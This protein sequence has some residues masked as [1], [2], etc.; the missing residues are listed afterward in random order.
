MIKTL[1]NNE[2]ITLK[3]PVP[4]SKKQRIMKK[5]YKSGILSFSCWVKH[6]DSNWLQVTQHIYLHPSK[7]KFQLVKIKGVF[8]KPTENESE[9]V[10]QGEQD[11]ENDKV[12]QG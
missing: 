6:N 7:T 5:K 10:I 12:Y 4:R 8:N 9:L 3:I 11:V 1:V 2:S